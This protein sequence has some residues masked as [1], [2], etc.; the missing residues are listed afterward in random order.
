VAGARALCSKW[1]TEAVTIRTKKQREKPK[2][3]MILLFTS[4]CR[5]M[6]FLDAISS[7]AGPAL[8]GEMRL[9]CSRAL[10]ALTSDAL[11]RSLCLA[12]WD[13]RLMDA[14]VQDDAEDG[15]ALEGGG[16]TG[17]PGEAEPLFLPDESRPRER[18]R[19]GDEARRIR[20]DQERSALVVAERGTSIGSLQDV[21]VSAK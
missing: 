20:V 2:E 9:T 12:G 10:G 6:Q 8:F 7:F 1:G 18:D 13:G 15:G 16:G 14:L 4:R 11:L 19:Q 17:D 5:K 21:S 3:L